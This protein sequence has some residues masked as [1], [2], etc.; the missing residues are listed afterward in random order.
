M[1]HKNPYFS[2]VLLAKLLYTMNTAVEYTLFKTIVKLDSCERG[3][4][5]YNVKFTLLIVILIVNFSLKDLGLGILDV[6]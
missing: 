6:L 5:F 1:A 2:G 3:S 4:Y